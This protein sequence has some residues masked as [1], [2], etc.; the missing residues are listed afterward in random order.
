MT[1][2]IMTLGII[3]FSLM[4]LSTMTFSIIV[5]L[6]IM[7]LGI[8]IK[9]HYADYHNAKCRVLFVVILGVIMLK[10]LMECRGAN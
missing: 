8:S 10:A 1:F 3:I 7:T 4:T 6:K 5:I 9:C 2:S